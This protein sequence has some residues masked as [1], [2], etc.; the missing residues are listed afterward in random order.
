MH[1]QHAMKSYTSLER[2]N[3]IVGSGQLLGILL[4]MVHNF[5]LF[6]VQVYKLYVRVY[7]VRM[8]NPH[9]LL[10]KTDDHVNEIIIIDKHPGFLH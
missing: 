1:T 3:F 10:K 6:Y 9:T 4:D 8:K 7:G 2:P 5:K